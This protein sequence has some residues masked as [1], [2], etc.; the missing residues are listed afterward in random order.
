MLGHDQEISYRKLFQVVIQKKRFGLLSA[1]SRSHLVRKDPSRSLF[2]K[3]LFWLSLA[4]TLL[5][6][7]RRKNLRRGC[8]SE[9]GLSSGTRVA[10]LSLF[11]AKFHIRRIAR[12]CRADPSHACFPL[13]VSKLRYRR[14]GFHPPRMPGRPSVE[15]G[16]E[17]DSFFVAPDSI[18]GSDSPIAGFGRLCRDEPGRCGATS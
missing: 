7:T 11:K 14:R 18:P 16:P 4:H 5:C 1:A 6:T 13:C 3:M 12:S 15:R 8:Y 9:M 2:P 10:K 17:R